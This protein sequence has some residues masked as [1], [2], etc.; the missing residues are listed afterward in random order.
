M[1]LRLYSP[2][3]LRHELIV[4]MSAEMINRIPDY[5]YRAIWDVPSLILK[6]HDMKRFDVN[7]FFNNIGKI[8]N[9]DLK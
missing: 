6:S 3:L 8:Y 1:R 7:Y 9:L 2:S 4:G 5:K